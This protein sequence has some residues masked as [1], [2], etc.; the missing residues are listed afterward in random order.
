MLD[1]GCWML[2]AAKAKRGGGVICA[3]AIGQ[4]DAPSNARGS[5]SLDL[6]LATPESGVTPD[7]DSFSYP[8]RIPSFSSCVGFIAWMLVST[9]KEELHEKRRNALFNDHA[10]AVGLIAPTQG[11]PT[12]LLTQTVLATAALK[13]CRRPTTIRYRS[14]I[15]LHCRSPNQRCPFLLGSVSATLWP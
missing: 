6:L 7:L 12:G 1:A 11:C 9:T 4:L 14:I 2:N 10:I 8:H 3:T 5:A 13:Q 15:F